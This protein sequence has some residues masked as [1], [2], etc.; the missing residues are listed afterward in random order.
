MRQ[1]DVDDAHHVVARQ[2][3]EQEDLVEAVEEL[4]AEGGA[5]RLH[6]LAAHRVDRLAV[7][8]AREVL[9]AE[10]RGQHDERVAEIDGAALPVGQPPVIEHLQQYVEHVGVGL[11]DFVEQDHLVGAAAHRLGQAAAFLIAD[12]A[13]AAHR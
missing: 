9:A 11:F 2:A 6:D 1:L 13:R 4:R 5:H 7:G 8:Q 10:V 3:A 12:I